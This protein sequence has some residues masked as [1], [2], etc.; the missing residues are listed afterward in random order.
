MVLAASSKENEDVM[1]RFRFL[2]IGMP[3]TA[4][5]GEEEGGCE[6][7]SRGVVSR[8]GEKDTG[9]GSFGC[10]G[11]SS[12]SRFLPSFSVGRGRW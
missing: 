8:G 5:S 3:C 4:A 1:D 11:S 7:A 10:D 6:V 2:G 9:R 12:F